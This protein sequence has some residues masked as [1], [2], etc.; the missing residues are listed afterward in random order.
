[1]NCDEAGNI[2]EAVQTRLDGIH[3]YD[4]TIKKSNQIRTLD[5]LQHQKRKSSSAICIDP[6]VLFNR[7]LVLVERST[8]IQSYFH[9]ELSS[10][11]T[12]PFKDNMMRKKGQQASS[13][14]VSLVMVN[15]AR[16]F[17]TVHHDSNT[18]L[19]SIGVMMHCTEIPLQQ[20]L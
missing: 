2:G 7:I 19:T 18:A 17:C 14:Q 4:T 8:D 5:E 3:F 1:L 15:A 11:P 13:C 20:M 12:A 9:Y 10:V 6:S 16:N